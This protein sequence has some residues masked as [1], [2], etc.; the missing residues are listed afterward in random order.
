[1]PYCWYICTVDHLLSFHESNSIRDIILNSYLH[2]WPLIRCFINTKVRFDQKHNIATQSA[3]LNH[4]PILY[5]YKSQIWPKMQYYCH[6]S[7]VDT[8]SYI[9]SLQELNSVKN[10]ILLPYLHRWSFI[11][12]FTMTRVKLDQKR[13]IAVISALLTPYPMLFI[14]ITFDPKYNIAVLSVLLTT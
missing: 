6:I 1:M 2:R 10:T 13:N 11:P 5:R 4:Y 9:L 7:N 14:T 3:L 8:L 12:C